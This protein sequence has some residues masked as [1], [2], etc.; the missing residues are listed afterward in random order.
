MRGA[1]MNATEKKNQAEITCL[2]EQCQ[3]FEK[4]NDVRSILRVKALIAYYKG[5]SPEVIAQCYEITQKTLKNWVKRFE[6]DDQLNDLPRS[7]RPSKLPKDKQEE[8]R[9]MIILIKDENCHFLLVRKWSEKWV[10]DTFS[11]VKSRITPAKTPI[12]CP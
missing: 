4:E 8:L 1:P 2:R 6:N 7:G 3:K 12:L 5:L 10:F 11:A 9:Q